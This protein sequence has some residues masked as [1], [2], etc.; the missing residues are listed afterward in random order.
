MAVDSFAVGLPFIGRV[1]ELALVRRVLD[2]V[3]GGQPRVLLLSGDAGVGKSRL[4]A[5]ATSTS[6]TG[7]A[8][9]LVGTCHEGVAI[10]YLPIATAFRRLDHAGAQRLS[11]SARAAPAVADGDA[12]DLRLSLYLDATAALVDTAET[13]PT[14]LVVEDVHWADDASADLVRHLVLS[15]M[16]EATVA[17]LP[18][19][20]ILTAREPWPDGVPRSLARLSREAMAVELHLS[21]FGVVEAHAMVTALTGAR[22]RTEV[23]SAILDV[24]AGNPLL[25]RGVINRNVGSGALVVAGGEVQLASDRPLMAPTDLD[26][27]IRIA[28]GKVGS[29][30]R[31]VL[32]TASVLG[33]GEEIAA[34]RAACDGAIDAALADA[35]DAGL[36]VVGSTR[37]RFAHPQMRQVLYHDLAAADRSDLHLQIAGALEGLPESPHADRSLAIAHHLRCGGAD[38]NDEHVAGWAL[39]AGDQAWASG[40]WVEARRAYAVA[41]GGAA[42]TSLEPEEL[43]EVLLRTGI[44]AYY[45]NDDSCT[46]W[47]NEAAALAHGRGDT[48]R[49]AEALLLAARFRLVG[50]AA[51]VGAPVRVEDL[52]AILSSVDDPSLRARTLATLA[53]LHFVGLDHDRAAQYAH[54]AAAT[55][56]GD[57]DDEPAVARVSFVL[58]LQEMSAIDLTAAHRSFTRAAELGD[59]HLGLAAETRAGLVRFVEGK[60][61]EASVAL[62]RARVG[63]RALSSHAGQ[64]MP[65]AALAAIDVLRG[66]FAEAERL[67][68]EVVALYSIQEY[69][70]TPGM[71]F[72]TLAAARIGRGDVDGAHDAVAQWAACGGRGTWRYDALIRALA[73]DVDEVAHDLVARRWPDVASTNLFTADIPCLHVVVGAAVADAD[74]V[75]RG[76]PALETAHDRGLLIT[77]GWPWLVSR[78]LADGHQ[79]LGERAA[80]E[81]WYRRAEAEVAGQA[82]VLEQAQV[83]LGRARI[84]VAEGRTDDATALAARSAVDLDAIDALPLARAARQ[85]VERASGASAPAPR[86]RIILFTDIVGSTEL[87]VRTG[88]EQ[89]VH[90]LEEHDRILRARLRRHGGVEHTHTGDG[91]SAWFASVEAALECCFGMH[92]DLERASMAHPEYPVRVRMG[93]SAGRPVDTGDGLFGLAVVTSA[94]ICSLA[95]AGQVLVSDEVRRLGEATRSFREVGALELKGFPG[96]HLV[97]E[98]LDVATR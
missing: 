59:E 19:L 26:D 2:G 41:L 61:T 72:P 13:G 47:L 9:V 23:T 81:R 88:D 84:A 98:A 82:V 79:A 34:L 28:L 65:S 93:L 55:L 21:R 67:G 15:A 12:E 63:E 76:L 62:A 35:T 27:E 96:T 29:A 68:A 36:L 46:S 54:E 32:T 91:V 50:T 52:E 71:V 57:I 44:A 20:V 31:A 94:R 78:V 33:D 73:G 77:L 11:P 42:R 37:F 38:P 24:T 39:R 87:N 5:E 80:A 18:L 92:A 10:P 30:C 25:M 69:A 43:T 97:H 58:G 90:L 22:P 51:T 1:D 74:L 66:S 40:A 60:L 45:A 16:H 7:G 64:Q 6:S 56:E 86:D 17:E 3:L 8:T 89:Y 85:V 53:D 4:V 70:F 95:G 48:T 83:A 14:I 75:R 49:W